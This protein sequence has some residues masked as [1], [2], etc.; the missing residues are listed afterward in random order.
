M[1]P[2]PLQIK[3]RRRAGQVEVVLHIERAKGV[4][5]AAKRS[6]R[7]ALSRRAARYSVVYGSR[8]RRLEMGAE[9]TEA[10]A[11]FLART[12]RGSPSSQTAAAT[13]MSSAAVEAI[14]TA[15]AYWH[16]LA[17][18]ADRLSLPVSQLMAELEETAE[19]TPAGGD[20]PVSSLDPQ[21]EEVLRS[22]G[23]LSVA[24]PP[25]SE[26]AS[27][28]TAIRGAGLLNEA[29]S[30]KEV[31]EILGR[32]PSRIR[33]RLGDRTLYG[34]LRDGEWR[35]PRFQF[36]D[37]EE[38]PGLK[39]VLP[40]LPENMHPVAV[41]NFLTRPNVDLDAG[42]GPVSPLDWLAEGGH[43]ERVAELAENLHWLP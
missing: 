42:T 3:D 35:L 5:T 39:E 11:T 14:D 40:R 8:G 34:V 36:R 26:R 27:T 20:D 17:V 15:L 25:L 4:W 38:V 9:A 18:L 2:V 19:H 43:P 24:M 23:S 13:Q 37:G 10:L 6:S 1:V 22:A 12:E 31:A 16:R 41:Y 33:Q 29:Y 21:T 30:V 28:R 32:N 7:R